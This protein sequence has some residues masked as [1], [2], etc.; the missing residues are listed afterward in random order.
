MLG[1][2][3]DGHG[4]WIMMTAG[5]GDRDRDGVSGVHSGWYGVF[6]HWNEAYE[7]SA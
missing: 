6:K 2:D 1:C 3:D 4:L 5:G 7:T